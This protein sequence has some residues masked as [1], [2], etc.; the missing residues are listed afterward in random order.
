V[1]VAPGALYQ[2]NEYVGV[3]LGLQYNYAHQDD[4]YKSSMYG[5]SVI[6]IFSPLPQIQLSAELEQLRVNVEY[7][8][9]YLNYDG[10]VYA[11]SKRNFWNTA[12]ITPGL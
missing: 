10:V 3:G 4:V 6:G 1:L 9:D 5:G 7:D 2:F 12:F 11:D 8:N